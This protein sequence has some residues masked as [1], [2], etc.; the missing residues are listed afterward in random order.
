MKEL[1]QGQEQVEIKAES[2]ELATVL[3]LSGL[4]KINQ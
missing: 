2:S 3:K 1:M 4:A